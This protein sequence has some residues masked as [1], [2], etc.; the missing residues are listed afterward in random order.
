MSADGV[1]LQPTIVQMGTVAQAQA[2][3]QQSQHPTTPFSERLDQ[4]QE[5]K[6]QRPHKPDEARRGGIDPDERRGERRRDGSG[7]R[8]EAG[9]EAQADQSGA[10]D[11]P[12]GQAA[13]DA[14][15]LGRLLDRR[16]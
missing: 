8:E 11:G 9:S 4:N 7:K 3:G 2:K 16:A 13:E 12:A 15:G 6:V 10:P 5:S 14:S 1:S